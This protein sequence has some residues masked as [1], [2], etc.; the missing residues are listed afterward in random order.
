MLIDTHNLK[1]IMNNFMATGLGHLWTEALNGSTQNSGK[2]FFCLFLVCPPATPKIGVMH[3]KLT[4]KQTQFVQTKSKNP[5]T[6]N[7]LCV[8]DRVPCPSQKMAR[9]WVFVVCPVSSRSNHEN[10][11][12]IF[13]IINI[14]L[15]KY[16]T[17]YLWQTNKLVQY[18]HVQYILYNI[19]DKIL[20]GS[21]FS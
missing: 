6:P 16:N 19:K 14:Y 1:Q 13:F 11:F 17:L 7:D 18:L 5:S 4:N 12:W 3:V 9:D 21:Y 10:I 15:K 2:S 20:F 8:Q